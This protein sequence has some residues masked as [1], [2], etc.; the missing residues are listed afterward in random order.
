M[1]Y[2]PVAVAASDAGPAVAAPAAP[3]A[4]SAAPAVAPAH[5][6]AADPVGY[7]REVYDAVRGGRWAMAAGLLLIGVVYAARRWLGALVP[8]LRSDRGGVALAVGTSILAT[9][10]SAFAAGTTPDIHALL[11]GLEAAATAMAAYVAA[12]KL[13][14]PKAPASV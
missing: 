2:A 4:A 11:A 1:L 5:D 8:W 6:V 12:K 3:P 7:A 14:P 9:I 13:A 10:G